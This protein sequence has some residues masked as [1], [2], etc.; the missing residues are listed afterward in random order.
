MLWVKGLKG[1][2]H[3]IFVCWFFHQ[4]AP[5]G[6]I[7]GTLG[8]FRFFPKIRKI[9]DKK[10][11]QRCMIHPEWRLGSVSYTREWR[12]GGVSYNV[13]LMPTIFFALF[14]SFLTLFKPILNLES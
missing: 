7:R 5:P 10:S 1:Q 2:C 3:K 11:V 12:L 13:E 6:L 8:Q 4:I 14:C 9:F